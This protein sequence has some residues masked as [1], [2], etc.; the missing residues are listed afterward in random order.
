M[1]TLVSETVPS[2]ISGVSQQPPSLRLPSQVTEQLNAFSSEVDGLRKRPPM[3]YGAKLSSTVYDEAYL[4]TINRSQEER[5]EVVVTDGDLRVFNTAG[6]E[7]T[8]NFPDGKAY[9]ET[10]A[11]LA[12]DSFIATSVADYTFIVNQT[13]IPAMSEDLSP[14]R[15][16]EALVLIRQGAYGKTY[17]IDLTFSKATVGSAEFETPDGS[18][19]AHVTEVSTDYIAGELYTDLAPLHGTG[20]WTISIDRSLIHIIRTSHF[21]I[22]VRDGFNNN[23]ATAF[24]GKVQRFSSLPSVAPEGFYL[25]VIGDESTAFDNYFVRFERLSE[26]DGS[27]VWRETV[28]QGIKYKLNAATMPHIL[29]RE[30]SGEF[31]FKKAPYVDRKVGDE[32][33]NA[34]PSFVGRKISDVFFHRNRLG[35]LA[36]ENVILSQ[37]GDIFNFWETTVATVLDDARIDTAVT[38]T[39][40][41]ELRS[42][43]AFNKTLLLFGDQQQFE[44]EGDTVL[45][46]S[47]VSAPVV[48]R[49]ESSPKVRPQGAGAG[50]FFVQENGLHSR[51]MELAVTDDGNTLDATEV[52]NQ[53]PSYFPSGIYRIAASSALNLVCLLSRY[54]PT[55]LG[56]YK[57]YSV[58]RER[59]Q[60][61]LFKWTLPDDYKIINAAFLGTELHVVYT[62]AGEGTFVGAFPMALDAKDPDATYLTH[63]DQRVTEDDCILV[64]T[65]AAPGAPAR[66]KVTFPFKRSTR[67]ILVSRANPAAP[68][69]VVG[70]IGE[71]LATGTDYLTVEGDWTDRKFFVGDTFDM[72]V[73]LSRIFMRKSQA[74]GG[75]A[76]VLGGRLQL[77]YLTLKYAGTGTFSLVVTPLHR[78]PSTMTSSGRQIGETVLNE[79]AVQPEGSF[80]FPVM[81]RNTDVEIDIVDSTH[82]PAKF[83]SMEWEGLYTNRDRSL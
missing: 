12:R 66:T 21:G 82:L 78:S 4:H 71:V 14:T 64:F 7:Q 81:C 46:A 9:L 20:G 42:V 58:G 37:A 41:A 49:F 74:G 51:L 30:S 55:E 8:V 52:T 44:F 19:P 79:V 27:G 56:F 65:A 35:F 29:V 10:G 40:A 17:R 48:S 2:L 16:K 69:D 83:Q 24:I 67:T 11:A 36:D 73:R 6:V 61:A 62:R 38:S 57:F 75:T 3:V 1:G 53:A 34:D 80:R 68:D 15:P 43:A 50:L 72:R 22:D 18:I 5:Y 23:G 28:K 70:E 63:L 77:R 45:T 60:S 76:P 33:S 13:V 25:E 54:K 47:S 31:T 59:L 32:K 39:E 26:D